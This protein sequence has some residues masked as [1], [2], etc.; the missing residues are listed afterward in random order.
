MCLKKEG[1]Y[2]SRLLTT[3]STI[4]IILTAIPYAKLSFLAHIYNHIT[5]NPVEI[6]SGLA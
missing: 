2:P 5:L 1:G 4:K 3:K 6:Y